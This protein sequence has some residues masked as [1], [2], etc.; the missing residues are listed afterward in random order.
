[1]QRQSPN[2]KLQ[3]IVRQ[4]AALKLLQLTRSG[5]VHATG[6]DGRRRRF[7]ALVA[8]RVQDDDDKDKGGEELQADGRDKDHHTQGGQTAEQ[9]DGLVTPV[10]RVRAERDDGEDNRQDTKANSPYGRDAH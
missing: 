1:M 10:V 5:R 2:S 7:F 4:T 9:P 3:P 8:T 6:T